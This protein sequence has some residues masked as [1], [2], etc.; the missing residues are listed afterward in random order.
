[1]GLL[2]D[3]W[4]YVRSKVKSLISSSVSDVKSWVRARIASAISSIDKFVT[5]I[6]NYVTN[7]YYET[8]KYISNVYN[9]TKQY[10]TNVYK[11]TQKYITNKRY[12]TNQYITNIIGA[13]TSWVDNKL[14]DMRTYVDQRIA[15]L[16]TVGFFKDPLGYIGTAFTGLLDAWIHGTV[17]SFAKGLQI[18]LMGNP[19]EPEGPGASFKIGFN[20]VI[21]EKED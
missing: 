11:T 15:A 13:S 17:G 20:S 16:D 3:V 5:N 7:K 14:A 4:D 21:D 19:P 18:G 9:T 2:S 6:S 12:E 8:K 1:M 10:L